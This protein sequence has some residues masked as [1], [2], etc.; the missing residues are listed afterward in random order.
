MR[1]HGRQLRLEATHRESDPPP[2]EVLPL[3]AVVA[4]NRNLNVILSLQ[5]V[6]EIGRRV[7]VDRGC[8]LRCGRRRRYQ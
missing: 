7:E 6:E 2:R 1:G 8:R 5:E 4:M 3:R